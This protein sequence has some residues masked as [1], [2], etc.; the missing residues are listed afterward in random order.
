VLP[1][2]LLISWL[3]LLFG[4][5][6]WQGLPSCQRLLSLFLPQLLLFS[7]WLPIPSPPSSFARPTTIATEQ[8]AL[9]LLPLAQL[10]LQS[11][12]QDH[13]ILTKAI[14]AIAQESPASLSAHGH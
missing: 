11:R 8:K 3:R 13:P 6:A 14:R 7:L 10:E 12:F 2:S 5:P 4:L 9:E 1:F